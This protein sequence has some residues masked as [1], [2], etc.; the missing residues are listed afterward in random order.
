ML[1][2]I[3]VF[4]ADDQVILTE[5]IK[6]HLTSL[7]R[8]DVVGT[9]SD[10]REAAERI[11]ETKPHV[12]VL[13]I[14]IPGLNGMELAKQIMRYYPGIKIILLSHYDD[15]TY[16]REA[17]SIGINGYVLKSTGLS[18]LVEAIEL[19]YKGGC[20]LSPKITGYL[21]GVFNSSDPRP[22]H[23]PVML[24]ALTPREVEILHLIVDGKSQQEIANA[25]FVSVGTVKSHK[26]NIMKKLN[27]HKAVDLVKYAI[28]NSIIKV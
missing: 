12:A 22:A 17:L 21:V 19:V 4:L 10:G 27:V 20:Y 8:F 3:K 18:S 5:A 2:K 6:S 24:H 13:D 11:A 25:L 7:G 15:D 28:R 16:V 1:T 26:L 14:A 23:E 9:A